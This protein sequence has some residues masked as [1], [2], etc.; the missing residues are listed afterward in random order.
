MTRH[1]FVMRLKPGCEA[2]YRRRHDELWPEMAQALADAGIHNYSI[3]LDP[4]TLTLFAVQE[5][6]EGSTADALPGLAVVRR[7]WDHMKD[8]MDTNPDASPV[9]RD[10]VEVFHLD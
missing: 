2:E 1:A 7:W 6:G 3:F 8:I 5:R 4:A 9:S 10:L